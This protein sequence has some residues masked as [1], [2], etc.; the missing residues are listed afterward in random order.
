MTFSQAA[1]PFELTVQP[2]RLS[3]RPGEAVQTGLL[4]YNAGATADTY[5]V[6]V[7]GIDPAWVF[8]GSPDGA[9]LS[10]RVLSPVLPGRQ[11]ELPII[12]RPDDN[13]E[14]RA[15]LYRI[16]VRVVRT[17]DPY[18]T[19]APP[20]E[21][22]AD[23]DL[24]ISSHAAFLLDLNPRVIDMTRRDGGLT[25]VRLTN[26][27][28]TDLSLALDA[29]DPSDMLLY[30]LPP[31][32]SVPVGGS[33]VLP[34]RIRPDRP[35]LVG[36]DAAYDFTISATPVRG[37]VPPPGSDLPLNAI[38]PARS[39]IG[40]ANYTPPVSFA[41]AALSGVVMVLVAIVGIALILV[42]NQEN[43]KVAQST[44]SAVTATAVNVSSIQ[45]NTAQAAQ[46]DATLTAAINLNSA[47]QTAI[48]SNISQSQT[49]IAAIAQATAT[50]D[51]ATAGAVSAATAGAINA[52]ATG[53]AVAN[54]NQ[55][56]TVVGLQTASVFQ[57]QT[58]SVNVA[59]TQTATGNAN[60]TN[61]AGTQAA[62]AGGTANA[63][64]TISA[65][66]TA[67]ANAL[68]A[69]TVTA[70]ARQ[71]STAAAT[72]PTPLPTGAP[73]VVNT[74]LS[75]VTSLANNGTSVLVAQ[76]GGAQAGVYSVPLN[77]D[78]PGAVFNGAGEVNGF[79]RTDTGIYFINTAAGTL[80]LFDQAAKTTTPV[81]TGLAQ[82]R[83]LSLS[84]AA[85]VFFVY[86][87]GSGQI[88]QV[89][90]DQTR[91]A[92]KKAITSVPSITAMTAAFGPAGWPIVVYTRADGSLYEIDFDGSNTA[93]APRQLT[94]S[95]RP[96]AL[97]Q[98][99]ALVAQY[100][101]LPVI[102][103]AEAGSKRI[104]RLSATPDGKTFSVE[105]LIGLPETP[106]AIALGDNNQIFVSSATKLYR[107]VLP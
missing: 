57:T 11:I 20:V 94:L 93:A 40:R 80:S 25:Q 92:T 32:V 37:A 83:F 28:N 39:V 50:S 38:G 70:I 96:G 78:T 54:L 14:S 46:L 74:N 58:A 66:A 84:Q 18:R 31:Q 34:L 29:G 42:N 41:V 87:S 30:D 60:A 98:P 86:E 49:Q 3:V 4:I 81:L 102:Y 72:N 65:N 7:L 61:A 69:A 99:V 52:T 1:A 100:S 47:T 107:A 24:T 101:G 44:V 36:S 89:T 45:T 104:T 97:S 64:G 35:S 27:G 75:N 6:T 105:T 55:T 63:N 26:T 53:Q 85:N 22:I 33:S 73:Q 13:P 67:T 88:T 77:G 15:G 95:G 106:T 16:G 48:R 71:T 23:I 8:I 56:A 17:N 82:P 76:G 2:A 59:G 91:K 10:G 103:V 5:A 68:F 12:I 51:A 21:R 79:A 90:F 43:R 9:N 62:N 19:G